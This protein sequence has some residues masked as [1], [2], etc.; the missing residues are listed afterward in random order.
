MI[1][2]KKEEYCV[3]AKIDMKSNNGCM[4]DPVFFRVNNKDIHPKTG[5]K[6]KCYPTYDFACPVVD[7]W[8]GVTHALRTNEYADRNE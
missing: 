6:Y 2:G 8:E 3:R 7:S 4:R 5:E 1:K